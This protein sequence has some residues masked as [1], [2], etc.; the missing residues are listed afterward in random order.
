M[1]RFRLIMVVLIVTTGF[2][3]R[4]AAL[5]S[6]RTAKGTTIN[7]TVQ[8]TSPREVVLKTSNGS[9]QR[10]PVNEIE[11]IKFGGEPPQLNVARTAALGGR[12]EEALRSLEKLA[13]ENKGLERAEV[14]QELLFLQ[15]Y[16][17]ARL[18][19]AGSGDVLAAGKQM[20]NFVQKYQNS[21]HFLEASETLGDLFTAIDK[22]DLAQHQYANV[23]KLASSNTMKMRARIAQGNALLAQGKWQ[24]A[25]TAFDGAATLAGA[26]NDPGIVRQRS[27]ASLGRAICLAALDKPDE[28]AKLAEGVLSGA[29][30]EDAELCAKAYNSLGAC[31]RKSGKPKD[32]L[33]AYL[34]VDLLYP[35]QSL[36]HA[37]A[38]K[39]LTELWPEIGNAK[40]AAEAHELLKTRY[41]NTRWGKG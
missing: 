1:F 29:D 32:A 25:Q 41:A 35:S 8:E 10:L 13:Q 26:E 27:L 31:L 21:Y 22:N 24:E 6:I 39:N 4:A 7:G 37:E 19:L 11:S 15:A 2:R 14:Q 3:G 5:D 16:C 38:L 28:G 20:H 34:H 12:Y 23:E 36:A 33:L 30:P 18:A 9:V 40:R 17:A